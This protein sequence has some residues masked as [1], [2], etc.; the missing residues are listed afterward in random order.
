MELSLHSGGE[1]SVFVLCH[2]RDKSISLDRENVDAIR[3][4]KAQFV[5]PEF[6]DM[7]I[8]FD[9]ETLESWYPQI[10]DHRYAAWTSNL[11]VK[12]LN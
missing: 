4:L 7:T 12:I 9:D 5:P 11:S 6:V 3:R 10:E 1:Y 2:V 8:M